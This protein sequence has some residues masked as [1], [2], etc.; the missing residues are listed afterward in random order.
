MTIAS[1]SRA[2]RR[3]Y[4]IVSC[5]LLASVN[6]ARAD[7][8]VD[9]TTENA[10]HQTIRNKSFDVARGGPLHIFGWYRREEHRTEK[11]WEEPGSWNHAPS[12]VDR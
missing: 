4:G 11:R 12:K 5:V 8:N 1:I 2:L 3:M 9:R 6:A 7:L 10:A